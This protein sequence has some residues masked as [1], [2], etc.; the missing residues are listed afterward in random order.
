MTVKPIPVSTRAHL[1]RFMV[2]VAHALRHP[3]RTPWPEWR[4]N[5]RHAWFRRTKSVVATFT[6][7]PDMPEPMCMEQ[8]MA[9]VAELARVNHVV[10]LV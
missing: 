6:W 2:K 7:L 8:V 4:G 5:D 10:N 1:A 3:I 9:P